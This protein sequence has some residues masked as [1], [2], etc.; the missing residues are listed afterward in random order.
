VP[1]VAAARLRQPG[2]VAQAQLRAAV[3][4]R[5]ARL[6]VAVTAVRAALPPAS[7]DELQWSEAVSVEWLDQVWTVGR[8]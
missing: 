7:R 3:A 5:L 4:G 6:R 1:R 2:A 8:C